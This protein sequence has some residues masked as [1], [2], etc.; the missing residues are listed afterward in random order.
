LTNDKLTLSVN[1]QDASYQV[2]TRT[3][4]ARPVLNAQ[5]GAQVDYQWLQS[6]NY[7]HHSVSQ[8]TF[9][10]ALGRGRQLVVSCSGLEG[11]PDLDFVLQLYDQAPY[12]AIQVVV[13]NHTGKPVTVQAIRSAEAISQPLLDLG[14][15]E[16]ADRVLSDSFSENWP[17]LVIYDLGQ[18][19]GKMHR[20]YGSQMIYNRESKQSLF[21]AALT[22]DRFMTMLHLGYDGSGEA[23]KIT[24][25]TVD[26][27]GTTESQKDNALRRAPA[28]NQIDISLPLAVGQNMSSERLMIAAGPDYLSQ[29]SAYGD[30]I[31]RL[32]NARVSSENM[33]GWWSWTTYYAYINE[34][35]MLSNAR[36]MAEHLKPLGYKYFHIDEGY[37][38][39]R[40]E[41]M[42]PNA[43]T[44]PHGMAA[45]GDQIRQLGLTFCAWIAP[46]EVSERAW[47]YQHHKDWLVH[48]ADG[49]PIAIAVADEGANDTL[50]A[51]DTTHPDAQEYMRQTYRKLTQEWG[52]H[53][54]K[55]DFMD[56]AAIEGYR[57]RPNTTALEAQRIGLQIIRDTVGEDVL[58]DKDG[59]PMLTPVGL[60]DEGR[61]ST[62]T[63]H[64]FQ[65][66]RNAAPGIAARFYMHR[67]WF[68]SD[69]DAFNLT[70][71]P[72][73]IRGGRGGA[74]R[75]QARP[76][77]SLSEAQ[78]SIMLSA[79][80]GG[81]FEIGDDLPTLA[82]DK[83][84]LALVENKDL[85]QV[86]KLS[87]AFTPMDLLSYESEDELPSIFFLR[88]GPRQ[89]MLAVFNWT[90]KPRTHSLTL[91]ELG[92]PA[93]HSFRSVDV[94]NQGEA[95][96]VTGGAIRLTNLPPHSVKVLK[97]I[98]GGIP[99]AAPS[100][101]AAVPPEAHVG[102]PTHLSAQAQESAVPA[103]SFRWDFGDGT[104]AEGSAVWHTF[105]RSAD[106]TVHLTVDGLDG[107]PAQ[108]SFQVKV[109][110]TIPPPGEARRL[111]EPPNR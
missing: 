6:K 81:M 77:V 106:T 100:I 62:D 65:S 75:G 20:G 111:I 67:N 45:Y 107:V 98:D 5:V 99:A 28:D 8:S 4:G 110:G 57:Y 34:G 72:A 78:V 21:L 29:L 70:P 76:T 9:T 92:L 33:L 30:A 11:K 23:A 40:G 32:H 56:T 14:G 18:A 31:R 59:S 60:V 48:T 51:L 10:D 7:P 103:V 35:A 22:A 17:T 16:S 69:P 105:T 37:Y 24:S 46:F 79:V 1:A 64:S 38:Y 41:Y 27:A 63:A 58:L 12:G 36:W 82:A 54:I 39:A 93:D 19:P 26:D 50:Y 95:S 96:G 66:T 47:I 13:K 53:Y 84:R 90:E 108:Q 97:L 104:N 68:V 94:L 87:R 91:A 73:V 49:K 74:G 88:Q 109:T 25:F 52:M 2:Q 61:T 89:S 44:F 43:T 55:L 42:T 85:L 102:E 101:T 86:A 15:R 71:T 3:A 80:S 83:A